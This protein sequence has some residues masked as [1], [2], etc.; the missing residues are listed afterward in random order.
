M[1]IATKIQWCDSTCN[2]TMGCEGCELWNPKTGERSCYAG[3]LH[4]RYGGST[5]GYSPTFEQLT[6]WPGR[7]AE[8]A[9]W[10]DL[11]GTARKD[12]PWLDGLPRIVFVSDMSDALSAVV[13]FGFLEEEVIRV[14]TSPNGQRHQWLWLTKRPDRMAQLF[15]AL[16]EEGIY[17]PKNLWAG[18]S[19]TTQGTTNRIKHLLRVGNQSTI[20]FLSV[21]PQRAEINIREWLP[22]LDW[23]IQGGESGRTAHPFHLEWALE[24]IGQCKQAGVAYFLKQLG[25][26]VFSKD[27]RLQFRDSHAGDWSQWPE[28]IRV[29]QMPQ[30]VLSALRQD[31][32]PLFT[33]GDK[34]QTDER[35]PLKVVEALS[36]GQQAAIKA[37]ETRSRI[38]QEQKRG[39]AALK[40][41]NT[42]K[43]NERKKKRSEAAKKAWRTRRDN[44]R[45]GVG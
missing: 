5:K 3:L 38:Q 17:W 42:R 23:V 6:Y 12:K 30:R 43:V 10:P 14:V 20:R 11:T 19:I 35:V 45:N 44:E 16:K 21:E 41:R 32:L 29:R 15:D 39:E 4:L 31:P 9:R 34:R 28:E 40:A 7:M 22:R 36:K 33:G 13:P 26:V 24:L 2:P 8:A 25:A 1:S 27:Q 37:W 18:T